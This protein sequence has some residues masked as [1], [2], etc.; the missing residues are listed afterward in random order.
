M[1]LQVNYNGG[2]LELK[3][4]FQYVSAFCPHQT[5]KTSTLNLFKNHLTDAY[6]FIPVFILSI[7]LLIEFLNGH[8]FLE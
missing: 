4:M 2:K 7:L 6:L 5:S 8:K 1:L 3:N